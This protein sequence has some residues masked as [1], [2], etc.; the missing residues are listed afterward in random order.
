M[1]GGVRSP[2]GLASR[3]WLGGAVRESA[4]IFPE[5][6]QV[7]ELINL[8]LACQTK[9]QPPEPVSQNETGGREGE[10]A[11]SVQ[12]MAGNLLNTEKPKEEPRWETAVPGAAPAHAGAGPRGRARLGDVLLA[13]SGNTRLVCSPRDSGGELDVGIPEVPSGAGGAHWHLVDGLGCAM[14][15]CLGSSRRPGRPGWIRTRWMHLGTHLRSQSRRKAG[16]VNSTSLAFLSER[17]CGRTA[18]DLSYLW[19]T[20]ELR[21]PS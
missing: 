10:R 4:D 16:P 14:G 17:P 2:A 18:E 20:L 12:K 19:D 21:Y 3:P 6:S 11:V 1:Q 5:S 9:Q 15:T 13:S 8:P 7:T